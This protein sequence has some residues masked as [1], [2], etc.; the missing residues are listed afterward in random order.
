MTTRKDLGLL[1]KQH[2]RQGYPPPA[3]EEIVSELIPEQ[4]LIDDPTL[5]IATYNCSAIRGRLVKRGIII[6]KFIL[7]VGR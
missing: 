4:G 2:A 7:L 3:E 5:P 6:A 1:T